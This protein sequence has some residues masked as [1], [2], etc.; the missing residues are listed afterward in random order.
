M[1]IDDKYSPSYNGRG[2]VWDRFFNFEE[3]IKDFTKAI[4]ID[5][6]NAVYWHNWACC[7][8]NKGD[9]EAALEDFDKAVE[10]DPRNPIIFSNR[11]LV[12][13][14]LGLFEEAIDDYSREMEFGS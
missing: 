5:P 13:W 1:K 4:E 8:W 6:E 9:L 14:K 3:A 2:L 11:G 7:F 12:K 10:L